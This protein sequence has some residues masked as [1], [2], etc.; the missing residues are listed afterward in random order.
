[1]WLRHFKGK[2][3]ASRSSPCAE[4][5][6]ITEWVVC[7]CV[8]H[9]LSCIC[10]NIWAPSSLLSW[11]VLQYNQLTS[12]RGRTDLNWGNHVGGDDH[13]K[14]AK[15][16]EAP[17]EE[18]FLLRRAGDDGPAERSLLPDPVPHHRD[19][20]PLL[21]LRVSHFISVTPPEP[22]ESKLGFIPESVH[23]PLKW[24]LVLS[25]QSQNPQYFYG[26]LIPH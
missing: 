5:F 20:L 2:E 13:A 10:E 15:M 19:L 24:A 1:M 26:N 16:G 22:Q 8:P 6:N 3:N 14:G 4:I 23:M 11:L 9:W 17:G 18:H 12:T 7:F 21:R 25:S